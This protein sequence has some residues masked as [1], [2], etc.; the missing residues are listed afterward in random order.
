MTEQKGLKYDMLKT[1]EQKVLKTRPIKK[2]T[3][4]SLLKVT[5]RTFL[6]ENGIVLPPPTVSKFLL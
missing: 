3:V 5:L 2:S 6:E 4:S 1:Y